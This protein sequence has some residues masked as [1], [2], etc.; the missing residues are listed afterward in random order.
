MIIGKNELFILLNRYYLRGI[1]EVTVGY[2]PYEINLFTLNL[3][4]FKISDLVD[5]H[6][7]NNVKRKYAKTDF[8]RRDLPDYH[9]LLDSFLSSGILRFENEEEI[10]ENFRLLEASIKDRTIYVKPIFIGIDTNVAYYR[11][12]SRRIQNSF[13]YVIS[14]IVIEEIDARIHTKYSGRMLREL[15]NLPY[16]SVM[17]EFANGSTKDCR[18]AKNAMNEI[19]YLLNVKDAYRVGKRSESR[20]KE[21]RDREIIGEYKK[22]S[23]NINAE[24]VVL[25]ADK[26]M[27]FHAQAQQLSSIYYKL[28]HKIEVDKIDPIAIPALLYDLTLS[29]GIISINNTVL[30]GEWRG[31]DADD[32]F[33]ERIKIYNVDGDTARDIRTCRGAFNDTS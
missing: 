21:V 14:E 3:N 13:K 16:H 2:P 10:N 7:L 11:I 29:F 20:D 15:E 9:D 19:Y 28:P 1:H 12:P 8:L 22:F 24:V 5:I 4:N 31:K 32:Y 6:E 25:T 33:H 27:V 30:L 18:R 17:Y 26:D 23:D